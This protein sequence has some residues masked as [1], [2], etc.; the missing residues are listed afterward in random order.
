[1]RASVS[2]VSEV[3]YQIDARRVTGQMPLA[4][5]AECRLRAVGWLLQPFHEW[6][7]GR[8]ERTCEG[9][10]PTRHRHRHRY[11]Q[12][13]ARLRIVRRSHQRMR[14]SGTRFSARLQSCL[15]RAAGWHPSP[16]SCRSRFGA[17]P[18][19]RTARPIG[20]RATART[21]SGPLTRS[22]WSRSTNTGDL[23]RGP[24]GD[25]SPTNHRTS[26]SASANRSWRP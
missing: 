1:M 10:T 6:R 23:R 17:P 3:R 11:R 22:T 19:C 12:Q 8:R 4:T 7:D 18:G 25:S 15:T 9:V 21:P 26:S 16:S 5:Q 20:C 24:G 14:S 2:P 13:Q